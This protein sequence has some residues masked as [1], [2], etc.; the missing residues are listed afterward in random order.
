[1]TFGVKS[2]PAAFQRIMTGILVGLEGV[3]CYM[4]DILIAGPDRETLEQRV[5]DVRERLQKKMLGSTKNVR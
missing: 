4:D 2:V 1:M 5:R 3:L